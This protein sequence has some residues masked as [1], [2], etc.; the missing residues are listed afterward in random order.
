MQE[1]QNVV[2]TAFANI[3]ASGA[4]EKAIEAKLEKTITEAIDNELRSYSDFGKA[5]SDGVKR[6]LQVDFDNL[7]IPGYNDLILKILRQKLDANLS[8]A[9]T[10]GIEEQMAELLAPAPTEITLEDLVD[11]LKKD[12]TRH[13]SPP[14]ERITLIVEQDEHY[15]SMQFTMVYLDR[16]AVSDKRSCSH[17]IHLCDGKILGIHIDRKDA[18]KTLF[19]GPLFGFEKRLFQMYAAGTKL[20]V[21]D[22]HDDI[23]RYYPE[24]D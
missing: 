24:Y 8:T 16:V 5:I 15:S 12:E 18:D 9:L 20:I 13:G 1:L 6:S 3:V 4:I 21:G 10:A 11:A 17:R 22:A 2:S 7:G 14:D 23:S 19:V